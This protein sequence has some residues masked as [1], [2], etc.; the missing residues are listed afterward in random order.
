MGLATVEQVSHDFVPVGGPNWKNRTVWTGD[1]LD[2]MRG[3]NSGRTFAAPIGA[4]A[5]G[6]AFKDAW[7]LSDKARVGR[8]SSTTC[9]FYA[10]FVNA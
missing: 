3:L 10:L 5:A 4:K 7:T 2:I 8:I 6:A 1:N 9:K